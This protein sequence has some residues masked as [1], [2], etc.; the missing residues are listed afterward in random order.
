MFKY[1]LSNK[2]KEKIQ[3][4]D[5]MDIIP[6]EKFNPREELDQTLIEKLS[7]VDY[8]PAIR[9]AKFDNLSDKLILV[10][11]NH[12]FN[13]RFL[14]GEESIPAIIYEYDSEEELFKDCTL[15]NIAHGKMLSKEEKIKAISKIIK[16]KLEKT[17]KIIFSE[18]A[19]ELGGGVDVR[20]LR[21]IYTWTIL[22]DV[23]KPEQFESLGLN[24]AKSDILFRLYKHLNND[25]EFRNFFDKYSSLKF[26]DLNNAI[27][28]YIDGE[29][30]QLE[31]IASEKLNEMEELIK[32][33]ESDNIE[34][35]IND[36]LEKDFKEIE[37]KIQEEEKKKNFDLIQQ[38]ED[39]EQIIEEKKY[40]LSFAIE[41]NAQIDKD[42]YVTVIDRLVNKLMNIKET[43]KNVL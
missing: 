24:L 43:V 2:E 3:N 32:E 8:I 12:R 35:N 9:L 34:E 39:V 26:G 31:N 4:V 33:V 42:G 5:L 23:L 21:K 11:G 1:E 17:D 13:S 7:K 16:Y 28:K 19:S 20:E 18:L 38:L 36:D 14:R 22:K 6:M 15:A 37:K 29:P 10:D 27:N 30:I 40:L 41:N 25:V